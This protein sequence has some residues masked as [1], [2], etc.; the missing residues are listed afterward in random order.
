MSTALLTANIGGI[1]NV[2]IPKV[3]CD[4]FLYAEENLPYPLP[5]LNNRL[6]GK[7]LK[8]Q[9]HRFLPH[10]K[11]I[12]ID[13]RVEIIRTDFVQFMNDFLSDCDVVI[14][15]HDQ[16]SNVYQE[17]EFIQ[18]MILTG[19]E[20]LIERYKNEP[21]DQEY[22]YYVSKRLPVDFPLYMCGCFARKNT[23]R[24]NDIF[25]EWWMKTLEFT[26]FDQAMFSYVAWRYGLNIK[27]VDLTPYIK[28][29]KH[30]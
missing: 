15:R 23:K 6:R 25:N 19:N 3:D 9:S 18:K 2:I 8:I 12:W 22:D 20:Y 16:R 11:F 1:D 14:M 28:Y 10:E 21:F 24:I 5:N 17:I 29:N 7:Y 13:G 27:E 26:L 4:Y 30:L